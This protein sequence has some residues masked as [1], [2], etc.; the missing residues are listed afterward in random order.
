MSKKVE[1]KFNQMLFEIRAELKFSNFKMVDI[2]S[3]KF[4]FSVVNIK[5]PKQI[6]NY[7]LYV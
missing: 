6:I 4:L 5:K 7:K 3:E 2:V 1:K